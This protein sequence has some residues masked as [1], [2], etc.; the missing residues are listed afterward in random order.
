ML[1]GQRSKICDQARPGLGGGQPQRFRYGGE[2]RVAAQV[3]ERISL[4]VAR[5]RSSVDFGPSGFQG[6]GPALLRQLGRQRCDL[7]FHRFELGGRGFQCFV[8]QVA[9]PWPRGPV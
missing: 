2:D 5:L 7:R 8:F 4:D 3:V 9:R 6:A 1:R